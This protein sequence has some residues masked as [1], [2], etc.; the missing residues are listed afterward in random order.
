LGESH[1][2]GGTW[3]GDY[4]QGW[5]GGDFGYDWNGDGTNWLAGDWAD[6]GSMADSLM[7]GGVDAG[8]VQE[9]IANLEQATYDFGMRS[10]PQSNQGP[11]P[12]VDCSTNMPIESAG[13]FIHAPING[14][15]CIATDALVAGVNGA[16]EGT[17]GL[18]FVYDFG[19][20][21]N[22]RRYDYGVD[23]Q[24][25]NATRSVIIVPR[26]APR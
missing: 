17:S 14:S 3:G 6:A 2:P 4:L 15:E 25:D 26:S 11:P 5:G 16:P 19:T 22:V 7:S 12:A 10:D 21:A 1:E 13:F 24:F 8:I 9:Q 18:T 20:G 23:F